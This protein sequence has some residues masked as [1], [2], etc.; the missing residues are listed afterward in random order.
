MEGAEK[1]NVEFHKISYRLSVEIP[2]VAPR[3]TI[4]G[5]GHCF[6]S[7][8]FEDKPFSDFDQ[9]S[10]GYACIVVN[11]IRFPF[12]KIYHPPPWIVIVGMAFE[13]VLCGT[14]SVLCG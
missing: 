3:T 2:R 7:A 4:M 8:I 5:V 14:T 9:P 12:R 6:P 10:F 13:P 1:E 11:D